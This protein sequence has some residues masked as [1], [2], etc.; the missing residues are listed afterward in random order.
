MKLKLVVNELGTDYSTLSRLGTMGIYQIKDMWQILMSPFSLFLLNLK[1]R[2][3]YFR[4]Y[5]K[6]RSNVAICNSC[7]IH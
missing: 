1:S 6:A 7:Q 3:L 2:V 4:D 5:L